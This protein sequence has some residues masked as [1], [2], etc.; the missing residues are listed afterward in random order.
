VINNSRFLGRRVEQVLGLT[1]DAT[2]EKLEAIVTRIRD[3]I[4][5]EAEVDRDSI[6]VF[7][8]DFNASSLD[9]WVAYNVRDA[10]F[11]KHLALKQRINLAIMRAVEAAGLAFAFP[12]QTVH[13]DGD[14]ARQWSSRGQLDKGP[15]NP[16]SD[17][18]ASP[19]SS[20][21]P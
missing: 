6:L 21:P 5:Q 4:T 2:P 11:P 10:D 17:G 7:F 3:I 8:R 20:S 15:A 12:T 18:N 14:I 16:A 9:I 19:R 13:F 1:Y